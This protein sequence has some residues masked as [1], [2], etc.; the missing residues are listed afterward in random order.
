VENQKIITLKRDKDGVYKPD[1]KSEVRQNKKIQKQI[2]VHRI[3]VTHG[4]QIVDFM[5]GI[6][7]VVDIIKHLKRIQKW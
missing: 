5:N 7:Q 1:M 4:T 2:K 6:N 3:F